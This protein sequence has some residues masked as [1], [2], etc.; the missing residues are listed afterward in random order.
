[1]K[2]NLVNELNLSK[3]DEMLNKIEAS[4]I[5]MSSIYI[6]MS[7]NTL[8][9]LRTILKDNDLYLPSDYYGYYSYKG[10][11]IATCNYLNYGEIDIVTS[12]K[13]FSDLNYLSI[14]TK[15]EKENND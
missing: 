2:L 6:L 3:L 12:F 4:N 5:N 9:E 13:F 11:K 15:K 7:D 1:M 8:K 10:I 14:D